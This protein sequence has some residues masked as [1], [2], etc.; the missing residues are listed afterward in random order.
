MLISYA[1]NFEDV[2]LWRALKV[3]GPRTYVDVGAYDPRVD[4]VTRGLYD[5]GFRGVHIEPLPSRAEALRRDRPDEQV[6]QGVVG[7]SVGPVEFYSIGETGVS[8]LHPALIK[9][10]AG[11]V[12][13]SRLTVNSYSLE[14]LLGN[15]EGPIGFLKID[16]EGAETD[17]IRSWGV[18][19]VRPWIVVVEATWPLTT[20]PS[21][22]EWEAMLQARGYHYV[23]F[24]GVNRFYL[25]GSQYDLRRHFGP[26][27]NVF[28]QF[29]LAASTS[30][31]R[32]LLPSS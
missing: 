16:V 17:V 4:S 10:V 3:G 5:L 32:H 12:D 19:P 20:T 25:H 24:D 2:I 26:G 9:Q 18:S 31:V 27:P 28:D 11:D 14:G 22:G 13:M 7:T 1:Q 23:Y 29:Q 21:Y 15:F 8:T 30:Y 6:V